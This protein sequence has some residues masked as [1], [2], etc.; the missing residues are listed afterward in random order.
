MNSYSFMANQK[1]LNNKPRHPEYKLPLV[2]KYERSLLYIFFLE[3]VLMGSSKKRSKMLG[4][5]WI[6]V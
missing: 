5:S 3:L 2:E 6:K 1:V 4:L